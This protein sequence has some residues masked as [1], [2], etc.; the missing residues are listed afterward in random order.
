MLA[1][2]FNAGKAYGVAWFDHAVQIVLAADVPDSFA[3]DLDVLV[4]GDG[5]VS[6]HAIPGFF[7]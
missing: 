6:D 1:K 2:R 3:A 7:D 5:A 4:I